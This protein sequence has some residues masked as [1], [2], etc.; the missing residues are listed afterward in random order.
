[1]QFLFFE[2]AAAS[3]TLP[4]LSVRFYIITTAHHNLLDSSG[5]MISSSQRPLP[6]NTK[7][8]QQTNIH[9]KPA[10]SA[11]ERSQTYTLDRAAAGTNMN[12]V[13][14]LDVQHVAGCTESCWM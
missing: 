7:H 1:M 9:V 3:G 11:G 8:S 12:A 2:A 6:D 4:A 10:I 5:R 14:L 13:M